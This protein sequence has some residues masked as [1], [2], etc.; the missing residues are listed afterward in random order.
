MAR[1]GVFFLDHSVIQLGVSAM[2]EEVPDTSLEGL[3]R[4]LERHYVKHAA[5]LFR[6]Y[7]IPEP[8]RLPEP[9]PP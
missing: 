5:G 2:A 3:L 9:T 8:A 4:K 7:K 1:D 6:A